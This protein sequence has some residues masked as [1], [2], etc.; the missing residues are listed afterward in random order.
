MLAV[1]YK[2]L[3]KLL[4]DKGLTRTQLRKEASLA[5]TTLAKLGKDELVSMEAVEKICLALGVQPGDI[6]EV[7]EDK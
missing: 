6:M 7:I 4:I 2:K 3:W 5:T 1:T